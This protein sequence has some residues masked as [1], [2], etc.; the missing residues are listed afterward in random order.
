MIKKY[1]CLSVVTVFIII[2]ATITCSRVITDLVLW[3]HRQHVLSMFLILKLLQLFII[4]YIELYIK[5][6]Q[7]KK[8][9]SPSIVKLLVRSIFFIANSCK[10]QIFIDQP[11]SLD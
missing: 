2:S 11:V 8:I 6:T 10:R 4:N 5:I 1:E 3:M 7:S 9:L